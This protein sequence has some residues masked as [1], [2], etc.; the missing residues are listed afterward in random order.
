MVRNARFFFIYIAMWS[1]CGQIKFLRYN[2]VVNLNKRKLK[3][4]TLFIT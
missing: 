1:N 3:L 2:Y 4:Y